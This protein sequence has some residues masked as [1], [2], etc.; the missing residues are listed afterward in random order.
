MNLAT[1]VNH[2]ALS[3]QHIAIGLLITL[4][5]CIAYTLP[6]WKKKGQKKTCHAVISEKRIAYS[7]TPQVYYRGNR[8]NYLITFICEDGT[9]VELHAFEQV[10]GQ[11]K[12]GMA[13]TLTYQGEILIKFDTENIQKSI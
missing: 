6:Y 9:T 12:E 8:W 2:N 11:L 13:G 7:N 10:Y 3:W 5:F 1:I 4:A